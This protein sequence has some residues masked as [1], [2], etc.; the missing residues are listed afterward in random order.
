MGNVDKGLQLLEGRP[1]AEWVLGRL[2]PQV[3]ELLINANRNRSIYAAFGHRIIEDLVGGFAG[4]LAGMHAGL[5]QAKHELVA[6]AP[7]DTPLLPEDLIA[8]LLMPLQDDRV[9][10]GVA[11]TGNQLHPVI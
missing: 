4:P 7:C 5:S 1:L 10:L 9:D 2:A 8:R 6:F 11:K 3:D